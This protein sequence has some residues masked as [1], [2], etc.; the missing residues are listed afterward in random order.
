MRQAQ[1]GRQG[2]IRRVAQPYAAEISIALLG[3]LGAAAEAVFAGE[4]DIAL[5]VVLISFLLAV[6]VAAI[7]QDIAMELREV[8]IEARVLDAIPDAR[9]RREAVAELDGKRA[10]FS[11]WAAGTRTVLE[12]SSLRY[13]I[14][15]VKSAERSIRAVHLALDDDALDMW[16]DPQRGFEALVDAYRGVPEGLQCRRVLALDAASSLYGEVGGQRVIVDSRIQEVCRTQIRDRQSG[17]L[18]FELR[19]QWLTVS[20]RLRV[21]DLLIVDDREACMIQG[22]GNGRFNDLEVSVNPAVVGAHIA[23]FDDLWT[24]SVVVERCLPAEGSATSR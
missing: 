6:A 2:S 11:S 3:A 7:R 9:W 10:E 22:F 21:A 17:G 12:R 23:A 15:V 20:D 18:G 24:A 14:E 8:T 1:R 5:I 4:T 16:A 19:I 13:Q